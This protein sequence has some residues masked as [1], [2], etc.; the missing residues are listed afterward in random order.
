MLALRKTGPFFGA[1]LEQVPEPARLKPD[2][3]LIQVK[4]A[5][6]CGSDVHAFEWTPGYEFMRDRLPLTLGHEF[7][8]TVIRTGEEARIDPGTPVA[9]APSYAC[10]HCRA[11]QQGRFEFCATRQTV[12]LTQDGAF[13]PLV[14]APA[15]ACHILPPGM[16]PEIAALTEPLTV[17]DTANQVGEVGLGDVVVVL[18]PGTIGQGIALMAKRRGARRVIVAGKGDSSRL[19]IAR[20]LG[21]TDTLDVEDGPMLPRI[22]E[23][24]GE[25]GVDRVFE[26]TGIGRSIGEGLALLRKG[27]ILVAAG[28][29]AAPA[30][31]DLTALVRNKQQIR[32]THS[33]TR[34]SWERVLGVLAADPEAVRPMITHRLPL[35]RG[36]EGFELARSRQASKVMLMP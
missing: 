33:A 5:G 21:A 12:G 35:D 16:D 14:V 9:V 29:H 28:I 10:M 13:A 26:A 15:R 6:I 8:G 32:G 23:M 2:E 11:C 4:A 22:A 20:A 25:R 24:V 36:I 19:A 17:G 27:G 30:E 31:I 34:L 18:G 7:A 1:A 3:V